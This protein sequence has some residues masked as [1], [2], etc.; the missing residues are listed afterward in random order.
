MF[1]FVAVQVCVCSL[2]SIGVRVRCVSSLN[3]ASLLC[4]VRIS[5]QVCVSSELRSESC[6]CLY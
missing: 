6:A 2:L 3:S 5:I 4:V 1:V